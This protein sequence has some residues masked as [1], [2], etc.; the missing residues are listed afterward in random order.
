MTGSSLILDA[1]IAVVDV[2]GASIMGA[3]RRRNI[4]T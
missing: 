1:G 3:L 4:L 2:V